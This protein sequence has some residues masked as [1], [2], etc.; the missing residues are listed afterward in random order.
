MDS[1][2]LIA[3]RG[4][5]NI[6]K[7]ILGSLLLQK[8]EHAAKFLKLY[9]YLPSFEQR[10]LLY[11]FLNLLSRDNLS[12][13]ITSED[14]EKWWQ[15]N[16]VIVSAAAKLI[17]MLIADN[18]SRKDHLISWLTNSSGAGIGEGVAIRRAA[19]ASISK[20]KKDME[21]ILE[22]SLS[23]FGDNLYIRHAP[24][25]QQE[26]ML[27]QEIKYHCFANTVTSTRT[28]SPPVCWIRL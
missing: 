2:D 12:L 14:D 15:A 16:A 19:I 27:L 26:G 9:G 3:H 20:S 8:E 18:E 28:S 21:N 23:Q 4:P 10:N 11:T 22:R 24:T 1:V 13:D 25:L 5:D 17:T 7:E 6:A